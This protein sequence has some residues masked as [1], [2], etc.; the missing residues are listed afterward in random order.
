MKR[1]QRGHIGNLDLHLKNSRH[2]A[3]LTRNQVA[4][5]VGISPSTLADYEIGHRQPSLP[6]LISLAEIYN[7]T[8]DYLLGRD[9][10]LPRS[11]LDTSN[12]NDAQ[13]AAL[14]QMIQVMKH[15]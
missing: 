13:I 12:L 3:K 14:R 11:S 10:T 4:E 9:G 2:K 7:V 15:E 8:T 1:G 5:Q 6:V